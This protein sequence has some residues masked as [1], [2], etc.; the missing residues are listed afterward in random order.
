MPLDRRVHE[1]HA[2]RA[3]GE[4][5]RC[6]PEKVIN[7]MNHV[8]VRMI[9]ARFLGTFLLA[10]TLG[11]SSCYSTGGFIEDHSGPDAGPDAVTS[12]SAEAGTSSD[13]DLGAVDGVDAEGTPAPQDASSIPNP[14]VDPP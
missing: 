4:A 10:I 13:H 7:E 6:S 14:V 1:M 9:E 12:G 2:R 3:Y 5:C 11:T 8:S